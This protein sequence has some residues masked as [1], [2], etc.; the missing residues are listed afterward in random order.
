MEIV[1][2]SNFHFKQKKKKSIEKTNYNF[3]K[4]NFE[5]MLADLDDERLERLI[6]N[7]D[8]S[9][10]FEL[11]KNRILESCRR[12]IPKKHITTNNPSWMNNDVTQSIARRQ[13]ANDDRKRNNADEYSAEDV[14]A[15]R[16]DKRAVKQAKR[17]KEI[18]VARLCK[19]NPKGFYSYINERRIVKDYIGP[20]KTPTDLIV[21]TDNDMANTL[22]TYFG[23]VFTHEQLYNIPQFPRYVGNTLDTFNFRLYRRCTGET[24]PSE[25][26]QVDRA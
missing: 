24:E 10:V 17:N 18:N 2:Q 12:H 22:N 3:R 8:A 21:T 26:V 7:S 13:R 16:L 20:L 5:A 6:V 14:T 4:E 25:R 15:R 9:Q 11:L 1:K 19:T 23:S